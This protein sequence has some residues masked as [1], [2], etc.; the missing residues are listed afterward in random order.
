MI[1]FCG[2]FFT[3]L[4][5]QF[6]IT[7]TFNVSFYVCPFRGAGD[8][9]HMLIS[10]SGGAVYISLRGFLLYVAVLLIRRRFCVCSSSLW[11]TG[12]HVH[13]PLSRGGFPR[14]SLLRSANSHQQNLDFSVHRIY[15][16]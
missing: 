16:Q 13:F 3:F 7:F 2:L 15:M 8:G 10:C 11:E 4:S 5:H 14:F 9:F 12:Y 6:T 1:N